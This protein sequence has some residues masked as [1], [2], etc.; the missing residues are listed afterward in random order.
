MTDTTIRGPVYGAARKAFIDMIQARQ[1]QTS[2]DILGQAAMLNANDGVGAQMRKLE[3][4]ERVTTLV[5]AEHDL[6]KLLR[7]GLDEGD[8]A[9]TMTRWLLYLAGGTV[10]IDKAI[11][12]ILDAVTPQIEMAFAKRLADEFERR[13]AENQQLYA[14]PTP[15]QKAAFANQNAAFDQAAQFALHSASLP[16]EEGN[17]S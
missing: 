12:A 9:E 16:R 1:K 11:T 3:A 5:A 17:R 7:P 15:E 6:A 2:W 14:D 13:I 10:D 4:I 8:W